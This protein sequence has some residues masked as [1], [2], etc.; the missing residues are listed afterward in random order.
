MTS[1]QLTGHMRGHLT[2]VGWHSIS[3]L[4]PHRARLA[5]KGC[6]ASKETHPQRCFSVSQQA[7]QDPDIFDKPLP[8][9]RLDSPRLIPSHHAIFGPTGHILLQ[10]RMYQPTNKSL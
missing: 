1:N 2:R 5:S 9:P 8:H 3:H 10:V 7:P 4:P 6:A